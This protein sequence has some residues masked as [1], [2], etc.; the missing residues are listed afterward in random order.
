MKKYTKNRE[1][2]SR[3]VES[4]SNGFR[5]PPISEIL[6]AY[7]NGTLGRSP[8]QRES[9]EEEDDL[10]SGQPPVSAIL[11]QYSEKRQRYAS[12]E[13]EEILQ[14]KFDTAQRQE[15]TNNTGL[16]DNLKSGVENLS[17]YS[18]DDVKVHYNSDKPAQLNA[19]AY[20][21]GTNI[22]VAP[23]QEKHLPHEAW[24][25]V[26]QKQG[27][28]QPT[29]QMQ[30]VN[31]NDNEGL[32][33]EADVMGEKSV[34]MKFD[35]IIIDKGISNPIMQG[36]FSGDLESLSIDDI[37]KQIQEKYNVKPVFLLRL[38]DMRDN[39]EKIYSSIEEIATD[40]KLA[41]K[42]APMSLDPFGSGTEFN[43]DELKSKIT[44]LYNIKIGKRPTRIQIINEIR[45]LYTEDKVEE[46]INL[47]EFVYGLQDLINSFQD[48]DFKQKTLIHQ[49]QNISITPPLSLPISK[50]TLRHYT[51]LGTE[52]EKPPFTTIKSSLA[53]NIKKA[54]ME[55]GG[56]TNDIDWNRYGNIGNTFYL[57]CIDNNIVQKQGFLKQSKWYV[58]FPL[59]SIAN[60]WL[61]S[62][63]LDEK[64]I[65]GKAIRGTG[66]QIYENLLSMIKPKFPSSF[67]DL[68]VS[69]F[70]KFIENNFHNL[71]AKI[72][73]NMDFTEADWKKA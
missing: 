17:G 64:E 65:K 12:E 15:K 2:Q 20:T 25:V 21:Q 7:R 26:Q 22:H 73:G 63:W 10:T 3:T 34:Q 6:Q 9:I 42:P 39:E 56:H 43:L 52:T 29:M 54:S 1:S 36:K 30:G 59:D 5:Q 24:H 16:P 4:N 46:I 23:G 33:K 19:L 69:S 11:Q 50:F 61:S 8:I 14:G 51:P 18:M 53:L 62:D 44:P 37:K 58:E 45:K 68:S 72:P 13:D 32:E 49:A 38:N 70:I 57:L 28:V 67:K 27:R 55:S 60:M 47:P 40:L 71:E 35:N 48:E 41:L 66:V 31:V